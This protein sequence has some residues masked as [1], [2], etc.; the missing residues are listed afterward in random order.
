MIT[1]EEKSLID[2]GVVP[3]RFKATVQR[4]IEQ[5]G[6]FLNGLAYNERRNAVI[7]FLEREV[8]DREIAKMREKNEY[9]KRKYGKR[10]ERAARRRT[11]EC[12]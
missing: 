8:R 1:E 2:R 7:R 3:P 4:I 9:L 11:R 5:H 12:A 6:Q 10:R